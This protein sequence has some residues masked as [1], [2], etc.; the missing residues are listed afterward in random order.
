VIEPLYD[1]YLP[2]IRRAGG[3]PV[4]V[5]LSPPSWSLPVAELEAA[6]GPKTKLILY[7]T[8]MNPAAKVF[9][10]SELGVIA[11]LVER[12]DT[13]A[14]CDEV[15]EHIC[16]DGRPHLPLLAMPG[17]AERAIKI[18]SA[19]KTFS[20]TG[21]KVG[22]LTA[23]P[24]LIDRMARAHQFLVFTTPPNLQAAVAAGL[25]QDDSYYAGLIEE[26]S[27][28]RDRLALGLERAGLSVLPAEGTY[29]LSIDIAAT[30]FDGDDEAFCRYLTT[31]VGVAAI[32]VGAF[33]ASGRP[34]GSYAR[35]CFA[36]RDAVLDEAIQRIGRRF[37]RS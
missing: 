30:G 12:W 33:Y 1:S 21:W 36:K 13:Y 16:F 25:N 4:P 27:T 23:A 29:F 7:N 3:I 6:F 8:P 17:M 2:I 26:M 9:T 19:G 31:E 34:T 18:G 10:A 24:A 14:L 20:L 28:K 37:G 5:R 15:Y 32:P 11:R 22:Y 35:F